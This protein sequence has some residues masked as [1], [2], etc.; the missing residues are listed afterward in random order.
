MVSRQTVKNSLLC[1]TITKC[2][3]PLCCC[4][5]SSHPPDM[6][7][8]HA[9]ILE[10]TLNPPPTCTVQ[11][12]SKKLHCVYYTAVSRIS[13]VHMKMQRPYRSDR[14]FFSNL[15]MLAFV[16]FIYFFLHSKLQNSTAGKIKAVNMFAYGELR[17]NA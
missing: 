16:L 17:L 2:V 1:R 10:M 14:E 4:L 11:V 5:S 9:L 7:D 15:P 12:V 6:D 3:G 8:C 13:S